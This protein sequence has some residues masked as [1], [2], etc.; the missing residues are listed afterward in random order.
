MSFMVHKL[1]SIISQYSVDLS[2]NSKTRSTLYTVFLSEHEKVIQVPS[3]KVGDID[4][5]RRRL[6]IDWN[7]KLDQVS[8]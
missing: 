5:T 1:C 8:H 3:L 2:E 7:Y 6:T 4:Q